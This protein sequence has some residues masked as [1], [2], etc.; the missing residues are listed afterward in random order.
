MSWDY[1][2]VGSLRGEF[3]RERVKVV[4]ARARSSGPGSRLA[5]EDHWLCALNG[6][7]GNSN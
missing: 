2:G 1:I 7:E 6:L 5:N 3:V 4:L